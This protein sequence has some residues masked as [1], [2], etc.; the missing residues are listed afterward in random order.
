MRQR[1]WTPPPADNWG[2]DGSSLRESRGD[3]RRS[4]RYGRDLPD[5]RPFHDDERGRRPHDSP[6]RAYDDYDAQKD[7]G[8][9][10]HESMSRDIG[11]RDTPPRRSYFDGDISNVRL[12]RDDFT[13]LLDFR[14]VFYEVHPNVAARS[15]EEVSRVRQQMS[16]T[17]HPRDICP[18]ALT[19][20]E[21]FSQGLY[22]N[23]LSTVMEW[24]CRIRLGDDSKAEIR[25]SDTHSV[26]KLADCAL[27]S[28]YDRHC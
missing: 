4:P 15:A 26:S 25:D 22:S 18:P 24:L 5:D 2:N 13:D 9:G 3:N 27:R 28:Q 14:R 23:A 8:Y 16:I 11:R 21:A 17:V 19:F 7:G 20:E 6:R 12:D 1:G 10:G